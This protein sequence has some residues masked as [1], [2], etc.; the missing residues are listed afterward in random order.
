MWF[1]F[2]EVKR[3]RCRPHTE[4]EKPLTGTKRL[5]IQWNVLKESPE[6]M[7]SVGYKTFSSEL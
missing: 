2:K 6:E 1:M 3:R 4:Q 5:W 7:N